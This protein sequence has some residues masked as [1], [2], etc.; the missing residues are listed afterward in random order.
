[1]QLEDNY[2]SNGDPHGLILA[3]KCTSKPYQ[4]A[5]GAALEL[6]LEYRT[7]ALSGLGVCGGREDVCWCVLNIHP[8]QK[9][10]KSG[11]FLRASLLHHCRRGIWKVNGPLRHTTTRLITQTRRNSKTYTE[12]Q[13]VLQPSKYSL[14]I[15]RP[16]F[17]LWFKWKRPE[18]YASCLRLWLSC[19]E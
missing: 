13:R 10:K 6:P 9:Q 17:P 3:L 8:E 18:S 15:H 7:A 19:L 1:M 2:S 5:T 14:I 4:T 12:R 16:D 11:L